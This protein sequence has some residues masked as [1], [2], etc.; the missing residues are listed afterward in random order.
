MFKALCIP[1]CADTSLGEGSSVFTV[2][3][4]PHS[5]GVYVQ[6]R[7]PQRSGNVWDR[8]GLLRCSPAGSKVALGLPPRCEP[9]APEV[10]PRGARAGQ[11]GRP[12]G[13]GRAGEWET[14]CHPP[15]PRRARAAGDLPWGI[16]EVWR[17][18]SARKGE[19]CGK[20]GSAPTRSPGSAS[21]SRQ[22]CVGAGSVYFSCRG[23]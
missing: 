14:T 2:R 1:T 9:L 12:G 23:E 8:G 3:T 7:K 18:R 21:K 22:L 13:G 15:G 10:Q 11:T 6:N 19:P 4:A 17:L 5:P 16:V 20:G